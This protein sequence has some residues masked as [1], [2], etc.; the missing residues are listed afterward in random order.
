[1]NMHANILNNILA[2]QIQGYIKRILNKI[3]NHLK[4]LVNSL[5]EIEDYFSLIYI[6][7]SDNEICSIREYFQPV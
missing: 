4:I 7:E 3:T 6:I 2:M 1:M 5:H